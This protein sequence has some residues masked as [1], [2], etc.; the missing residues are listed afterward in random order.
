[1]SNPA[2][3]QPFSQ[4]PFAWDLALEARLKPEYF[5]PIEWPGRQNMNALPH[6]LEHRS[7]CQLG[8]DTVAI[9][10]A[11]TQYIKTIVMIYEVYKYLWNLSHSRYY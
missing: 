10:F 8:T 6:A 3:L 5:D 7:K 11:M 9:R 4:I 1:M 2:Q